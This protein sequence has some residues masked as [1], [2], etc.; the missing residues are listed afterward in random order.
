MTESR[1]RLMVISRQT[2]FKTVSGRKGRDRAE[3]SSFFP[4][5]YNTAQ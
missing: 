2:E 4:Y 1:I 3:P 5:T